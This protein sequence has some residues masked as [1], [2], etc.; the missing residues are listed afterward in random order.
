MAKRKTNRRLPSSLNES[1]VREMVRSEVAE[2]VP[3]VETG[4]AVAVPSITEEKMQAIVELCHA[5]SS[6]AKS[7]ESANVDVTISNCNLQNHQTGIRI[8]AD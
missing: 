1:Q 8:L 4:I 6:L 7:L 3:K 2:Q 5:V